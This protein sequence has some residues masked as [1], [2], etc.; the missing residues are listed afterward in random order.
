MEMM[1]HSQIT[2]A[3]LTRN[4]RPKIKSTLFKNKAVRAEVFSLGK[5]SGNDI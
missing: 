1:D 4:I 5:I 2:K 3:C